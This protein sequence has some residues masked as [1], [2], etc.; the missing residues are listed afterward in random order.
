MQNIAVNIPQI[1]FNK[2]FQINSC[3]SVKLNIYDFSDIY[4]IMIYNKTIGLSVQI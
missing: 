1:N 4:L 3:T 2:L